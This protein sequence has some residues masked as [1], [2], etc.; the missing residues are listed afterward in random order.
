MRN[1]PSSAPLQGVRVQTLAHQT[2]QALMGLSRDEAQMQRMEWRLDMEGRLAERLATRAT[3]AGRGMSFT[4]T[5]SHIL[6]RL[7]GSAS[8]AYCKQ[9]SRLSRR[10]AAEAHPAVELL[11]EIVVEELETVQQRSETSVLQLRERRNASANAARERGR[12]APP[13][14]ELTVDKATDM[15][16]LQALIDALHQ[17]ALRAALAA[18][19]HTDEAE[20]TSHSMRAA[21]LEARLSLAEAVIQLGSR[22]GMILQVTFSMTKRVRRRNVLKRVPVHRKAELFEA[23]PNLELI[24]NTASQWKGLVYR[25]ASWTNE[26]C[27]CEAGAQVGAQADLS[28]ARDSNILS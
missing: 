25:V 6:T 24:K 19:E 18:W 8:H 17:A 2:G 13:G 5:A 20:A 7:R 11:S 10:M 16:T 22:T 14:Q 3:S 27:A 9:G 23:F 1:F 21:D 26:R 4:K 15:P 28:W 12:A